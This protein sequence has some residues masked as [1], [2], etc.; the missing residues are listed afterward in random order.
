MDTRGKTNAEFKNE[1]NEILTRHESN[2]DCLNNNFNQVNAT[3][4]TVLAELQALRVNATTNSA[5]TEV[6]PFAPGESSHR[7]TSFLNQIHTSN[8]THDHNQ[9][10][11]KLNFP[12]F[13]GS[14][15][16]GWIFKAE[17]YFEFKGINPQ[18]Q[19]QLASFHLEGVALQWNR[20]FTKF[21]GPSTWVEFTQAI[22]RRF[23]PTDYDDPS[24]ALG[25]LKQVTTV[26]AYQE[27]FE[28][29]SHRVDNLPESHLVGSFIA[30]LKDDVRLDVRVKQPRTLSDAISVAR[31]IE[32]R[33][34]LQRRPSFPTRPA[35][36]TPP[37]R[38]QPNTTAGILG[39][40]PPQKTTPMA[41][42][43]QFPFRRITGQETKARREKGLCYYCD[44]KYMPGHR[45]E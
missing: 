25:R 41:T 5:A 17:Q 18:Q 32:E 2:F 7:P 39:P 24:E 13:G 40:S 45:C 20:W 36:T 43:S 12:T 31:L 42:P 3:L 14:D 33:N 1:V 15:P 29:L 16:T 4:Q 21:R 37:S 11:L 8:A 10:H 34:N 22:L 27:Q 23:G 38:L 19:V 30:G 9:A 26:A 44:E 6:N 28:Q 35:S